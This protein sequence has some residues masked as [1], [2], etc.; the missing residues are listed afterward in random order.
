MFIF[1]VNSRCRPCA[2]VSPVVI[3][4]AEFFYRVPT[5]LVATHKPSVLTLVD[6]LIVVSNGRIIMGTGEEVRTRMC[7]ACGR[8]VAHAAYRATL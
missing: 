5:L 4:L 1:T 8:T 7:H 6:R 3:E 2:K